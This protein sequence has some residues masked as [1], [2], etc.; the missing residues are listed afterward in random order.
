MRVIVYT[1]YREISLDLFTLSDYCLNLYLYLS[2]YLWLRSWSSG[3]LKICFTH[4][5]K[6]WIAWNVLWFVTHFTDTSNFLSRTVWSLS[7]SE[8]C[9]LSWWLSAPKETSTSGSGVNLNPTGTHRWRIIRIQIYIQVY[10]RTIISNFFLWTIIVMIIIKKHIYIYFSYSQLWNGVNRCLYG[11][12]HFLDWRPWW[13]GEKDTKNK[14]FD[15]RSFYF[16]F[17]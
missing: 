11:Y 9:S 3:I 6:T 14:K 5:L 12:K 16:L 13:W 7:A 15:W 17:F 1:K 10:I 4:V 2:N 8:P